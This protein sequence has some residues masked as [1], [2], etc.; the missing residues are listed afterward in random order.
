MSECNTR[1]DDEHDD[2]E[3]KED[4]LPFHPGT[5]PKNQ[6]EISMLMGD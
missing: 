5:D 3:E 1:K 2:K 6:S 4:E